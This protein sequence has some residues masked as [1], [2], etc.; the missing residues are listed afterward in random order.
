MKTK[1]I[2]L[3]EDEC[4]LIES[5]NSQTVIAKALIYNAQ[6]ALEDAQENVRKH[7]RALVEEE[8]KAQGVLRTIANLHGVK[9]GEFRV[10][11]DLRRLIVPDNASESPDGKI[12]LI[13]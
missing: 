5:A 4:R 11:D 7:Q 2:P 6:I 12:Q 3:S 10:S 13:G 9:E 8:A 1:D